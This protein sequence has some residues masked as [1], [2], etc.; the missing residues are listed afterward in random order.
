M[1]IQRRVEEIWFQM[2]HVDLVNGSF[3]KCVRLN[4]RAELSIY[5]AVLQLMKLL[6]HVRCPRC[7]ENAP[8]I[9]EGFLHK[10]RTKEMG[11]LRAAR[12]VRAA[13]TRKSSAPRTIAQLHL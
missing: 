5:Q 4:R 8:S 10:R 12:T 2:S 1:G 11:Y 6:E 3:F 13:S 7:L 9:F